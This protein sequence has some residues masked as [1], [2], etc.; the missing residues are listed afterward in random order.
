MMTEIEENQVITFA[1]RT[2]KRQ[3]TVNR[4]T[5]AMAEHQPG[6][7][8]IA[9][10]AHKNQ[11]AVFHPHVQCSKSSRNLNHLLHHITACRCRR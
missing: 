2:P 1:Q 9:V 11:C 7:A 8:R 3:V 5:V 10:L 4:Q 6:S